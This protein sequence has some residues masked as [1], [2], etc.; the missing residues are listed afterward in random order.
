[1]QNT[2]P[3]IIVRNHSI[4]ESTDREDYQTEVVSMQ[5]NFGKSDQNY[6]YIVCNKQMEMDHRSKHDLKE[7]TAPGGS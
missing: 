1:M 5:I 3:K 4:S 7:V 6:S 2:T